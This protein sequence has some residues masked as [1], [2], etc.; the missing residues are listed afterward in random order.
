MFRCLLLAALSAL[1][2]SA[3][4]DTVAIRT[5]QVSADIYYPAGHASHR[6]AVLVLG[7]AEGGSRWA[8]SV[9]DSLA[10]HGYVAMAEAYFNAPGLPPQLLDVPL[11]RLRAGLDRL[12]ADRRVDKHRLAVLGISK[13]AEAALL[14]AS[15]DP[16]VKAVVAGS[17]SDVVFQGI[18]RKNGAVASSWTWRGAP[19]P[20][21]PFAPCAACKSLA[22]LYVASRDAARDNSASIEVAHIGAPL[23]LLSSETDSV[24]P[25]KAMALAILARRGARHGDTLLDYPDGGHF[26]LGPSVP[27][28]AQDD[29]TY[30]GGTKDGVVAARTASWPRVLNFLDDALPPVKRKTVNAA[31]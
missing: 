13:G 16:R 20:F 9:A 12:A 31:R 14:V 26:T 22:D 23:L 1:S 8:K 30:G 7:G 28:D 3:S 27:A 17:P 10:A 21:V 2:F 18:D 15:L 25:S 11:E 4:A 19:L 24:W 29:V 6:P 5:P